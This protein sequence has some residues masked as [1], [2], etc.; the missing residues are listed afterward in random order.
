MNKAVQVTLIANAGVLF[1]YQG[2]RVL[3]D[4]LHHE[5]SSEFSPVPTEYLAA[6]AKGRGPLKDAEYLLFTHLHPDH[7]SQSCLLEYIQGNPV[8]GVYLPVMEANRTRSCMNRA[9][10]GAA[11][12]HDLRDM[13]MQTRSF[14]LQDGFQLTSLRAPHMAWRKNPRL[15]CDN[16]CFILTAGQDNYVFVGDCECDAKTLSFL[17]TISIRAVFVNPIFFHLAEGQEI[18][19]KLISPEQVVIYHLP[20]LAGDTTAYNR[21]AARDSIRYADRFPDTVLL[22]RQ[23]QTLLL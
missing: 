14:I 8:K 13:R 12:Y 11:V 18:L 5:T 9:V 19:Q 16:Y 4:G 7:F 2:I 1:E 6:A 10:T 17:E 22:N 3:V 20:F 23:G 21:I 15:D